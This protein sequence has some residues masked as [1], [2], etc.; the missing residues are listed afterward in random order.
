MDYTA[1]KFIVETSCKFTANNYLK[2]GWILLNIFTSNCSDPQL[3]P[4]D[5]RQVYVLGA[6]EGVDYSEE[7][8]NLNKRNQDIEELRKDLI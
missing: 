3:C 5:L 6:I 2:R 7:L 8:D 4:N 1:I